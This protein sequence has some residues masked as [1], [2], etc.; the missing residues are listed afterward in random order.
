MPRPALPSRIAVPPARPRRALRWLLPLAI[1]AAT[2]YAAAAPAG[3]RPVGAGALFDLPYIA[4]A[5]AGLPDFAPVAMLAHACCYSTSIASAD[6]DGDGDEDLLVGNGMSFD[7]SVL[8]SDGA[9]GHADPVNLPLWT[10]EYGLVALATGDLDGDGDIDFAASGVDAGHIQL[11]IGNGSGGFTAG[12]LLDIGSGAWPRSLAIADIDGD[13]DADLASANNDSASVSILLGDGAGGFAAAQGFATGAYPVALAIA[14]IDEDGNA[15]IATA[16]AGSRD[17]SVLLGDGSGQFAAPVAHAIGV[18]AEPFGIALGDA[19]GDGHVDILTANPGND[20]SPFPPPELEGSVSLLTGDGA[21]GFAAASLLA[22]GGG[23]GRAHTVALG[24][25]TSDGHAD[26]VASRPNANAVTVIP[27]DGAG[28]FQPAFLRPT[29]V[30]PNALALGDANGDARLDVVTANAVGATVSIL[31]ADGAGN[32][33]F[34]GRHA[35]GRY[36]HAVAAA[37][38]DGDGHVDVATAN[39]F[40]NDVSVLRNDGSGGFVP[41]QSHAVGASPTNLVSGDVDGDGNVDLL[42][43]NLGGGD[44]SVLLG[45]GAGGFAAAQ[46]F[47]VSTSFESPYALALGDANGDGNPDVATANTNISNESLSLLLGDGNGGFGAA[48]A[49]PL[50]EPGYYSPQGIVFADVTG[51][52]HDDIVS[53][54]FGSNNLSLLAGDGSGA[55]SAAVHLAVDGGPVIVHTAD[56]DGDG[57]LD[58]VTANQWGQSAAVLLADGAGGFAPAVAYAIYPPQAVMEFD[59]W[60]WGLAL[61]DVTGDGLPDIAT[62]NTQN[63]TVSVLPNDGNGA[64]GSYAW[65]A[66]GANPGAVAIADIDGDGRNDVVS[67]NRSNDDIAVLRNATAGDAIFADGFDGD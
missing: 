22:L 19:D 34:P 39:A 38:F 54:N 43:A 16:N 42:T 63:D 44:V 40:G 4:P 65:F 13:G 51:D 33:G 46:S 50:G 20:G 21:G 30:G 61:G 32:V 2:G 27:G 52:G 49:L 25:V 9:G 48:I 35:A 3:E 56:M 55:F 60:P 26:I 5:G 58:L 62:A 36:P 28:G 53:A 15:D 11:F 24:D 12:T 66:S 59:A 18:D 10:N 37:D 8:L 6:F 14:D 29:G 7:V 31:P 47:P 64:F 57:D 45:D 17:V 41:A 1:L 67:A 23:D